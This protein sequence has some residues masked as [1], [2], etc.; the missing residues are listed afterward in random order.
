LPDQIN[1]SS[2]APFIPGLPS[3]FSAYGAEDF[4]LHLET[5]ILTICLI[6][7]TGHLYLLLLPGQLPFRNSLWADENLP[8]AVIS[9]SGEWLSILH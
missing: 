7:S 1:W 4:N 5:L 3:F 6:R 9:S 2:E 8:S